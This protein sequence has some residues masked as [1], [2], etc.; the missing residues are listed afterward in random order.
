MTK[1]PSYFIYE[2]KEVTVLIVL[3]L[4]LTAFAFTLGVHLGKRVGPKPGPSDLADAVP[5]QTQDEA[6]PD[7][8]NLTEQGEG[9][10]AAVTETLDTALEAEVKKTG[11]ELKVKKPVDLPSQAKSPNAGA[12]TP[13]D[14]SAPVDHTASAPVHA[15]VA[16]ATPAPES[17][18]YTIQVGSFPTK[19]EAEKELKGLMTKGVE[20]SHAPFIRQMSVKGKGDWFRLYVGGF[21]SKKEAEDTADGYVKKQVIHKYIVARTP[22]VTGSDAEKSGEAPQG[23]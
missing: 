7:R 23:H 8:V 2:R 16:V 3:A 4:A 22:G 21:G 13:A 18:R 19:A 10:E 6:T 20:K 5:A 15:P 1:R 11:I 9:L 14:H 17:L 12:T